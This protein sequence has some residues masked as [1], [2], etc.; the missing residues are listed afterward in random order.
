MLETLPTT[1]EVVRGQ[2]NYLWLEALEGE[3]VGTRVPVPRR[4]RAYDSDTQQRIADLSPGDVCEVTLEHDPT[5]SP[6]WR[7]ASVA[8]VAGQA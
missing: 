3:H 8:T 4:N 2:N 7:I 6:D 5:T 1:Y